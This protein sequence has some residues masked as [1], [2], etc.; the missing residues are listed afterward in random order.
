MES[1]HLMV[2]GLGNS[3]PGPLVT[4]CL[5]RH[6]LRVLCLGGEFQGP[7]KTLPRVTQGLDGPDGKDADIVNFLYLALGSD[8]SDC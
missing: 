2:T 1:T 5:N 8:F 4:R 3:C 7:R 6:Q